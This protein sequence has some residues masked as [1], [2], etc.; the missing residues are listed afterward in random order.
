M[1][2]MMSLSARRELARET[3]VRYLV[4]DRMEKGR[5]LDEFAA[6]AGYHRKYALTVLNRPAQEPRAKEPRRR[7]PR[8]KPPVVRAL[9]VAWES[10]GRPCGKRLVPFL[11]ELVPVLIRFGELLI[12]EDDQ[13]LLLSMSAATADRLL[14][15]ARK[16]EG[17]RGISTTKPG[18]LLKRQIPVHTRYGWN[19]TQPGFCEVDLVAHCGESTHGYYLNTLTLTDIAT[20][21]TE[22]VALQRRSQEIVRRAVETARRRLPFPLRA[23]DCDNGSEFVNHLLLG[24]CRKEG[25]RLTRCRPY[26]KNDQAHVEQKNG[27][28][29]RRVVGYDRYE[30]LPAFHRLQAVHALSRLLVN[31][32]QP[33]MKLIAKERDDGKV[34]KVYDEARTPFQRTLACEHVQE[35]DKRRLADLYATLNP[36]KITR[37]LR[38][39][40]GELR[41]RASV[42][43]VAAR[44]ADVAVPDASRYASAPCG[45]NA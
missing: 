27:S 45:G 22:C 13:R 42:K 43:A 33:S 24:Y 2:I 19:D 35:D 30:G 10:I 18:P 16:K 29:V 21:W 4:A 8:Y 7:K 15:E 26:R 41:R 1:R 28:I 37:E 11:P 5:I 36:A 23:L 31:F 14:K 44:N 25:I 40:Q 20:G 9:L 6:S 17:V 39:A 3:A 38:L 12:G 32:F 34:R